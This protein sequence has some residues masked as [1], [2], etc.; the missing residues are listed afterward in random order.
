MPIK[1]KITLLLLVFEC[2]IIKY[3]H[4]QSY[5][6]PVYS[7]GIGYGNSNSILH[8]IIVGDNDTLNDPYS[9][10][11][12]SN[13]YGYDYGLVLNLT[14]GNTY[15]GSIT[16]GG[17]GFIN[18]SHDFV[19]IWIDYNDD[20]IFS[21]NETIALI[22]GMDTSG[23][24]DF[25]F[26]VPDT[27]FAST[28]SGNCRIRVRMVEDADSAAAISPC[29]SA[30]YGETEDYTIHLGYYPICQGQ[31]E[32]GA[33][34]RDSVF[35]VCSGEE[36]VLADTG[37]TQNKAGLTFQWQQKTTNSV[38]SNI[39]NGNHLEL[40]LTSGITDTTSF[41]FYILCDSS[42]LSDTSAVITAVLNPPDMCYC[43]PI[44]P[45]QTSGCYLG[46][47][48]NSFKLI[49]D[50]D[51]LY[52]AN[53]GCSVAAFGDF[54]ALSAPDLT[55]GN[56]YSG[57]VHASTS[58]I[59]TPSIPTVKIWIDYNND[60]S[61]DSTE[62]VAGVYNPVG[63]SLGNFSFT[64][65]SSATVGYHRM[66]LRFQNLDIFFGT[67]SLITPCGNQGLGETEDYTVYIKSASNCSGQ[68]EAGV[69]KSKPYFKVCSGEA[70]SLTDT[71]FSSNNGI[72]Y[73]WQQR[74][75]SG[76]GIWTN[77]SG[78]NSPMLHLANGITDS[79]DFRF[80]VTCS[81]NGLSDTT[82]SVTAT[83]NESKK[84]F[85]IPKYDIGCYEVSIQD[86]ILIGE[87]TTLTNLNSGCSP[88]SYG[89]YTFLAAPD[90]LPMHSYAT[91]I[92][93]DM[94]L[95]NYG[96]ARIWIDFND[97]GI[98]S[99]NETVATLDS[100]MYGYAEDSIRVSIPLYA[101][102]GIHRLR[103]RV[104]D[105]PN[106]QQIDP[107]N[108]HFNSIGEAEDYLVAI[109][110]LPICTGQPEAGNLDTS[111]FSICSGIPFVLKDTGASL[112]STM[113]YQWQKRVSGGSWTDIPGAN[114]F[115]LNDSNGVSVSTDFR[116]YVICTN[117]GLRDSSA[118][119]S[120]TLNDPT[121]C[122]C[123]PAYTYGCTGSNYINSFSLSGYNST[124][125]S[126]PNNGCG[127]SSGYSD[128]TTLTPPDFY[129]GLNYSGTMVINSLSPDLEDVRIWIDLN[130]D[131]IFDSTE[132]VTEIQGLDTGINNFSFS[133]PYFIDSGQHRMRVRMVYTLPPNQINPCGFNYYG[134]TE[135]Y[136]LN[137]LP[138]ASCSGQPDAGAIDS[139][140]VFHI[141]AGLPFALTDTGLTI[142]EGIHFQW[143]KRSDSSNN[144]WVD[145][146]GATS[147][148]LS[149]P[150]GVTDT[151]K[152]RFYV[153]CLNSGLS[154]TS[155]AVTAI[156]KPLLECYCTPSY[157]V[158]CDPLFPVDI[159]GFNLQ[160]E[161]GTS[162]SNDNSGCSTNEVG[163]FTSLAAPDLIPGNTYSGSYRLESFNF[164]T[165]N[166]KIWI[167]YNNNA[168]FDNSEVVFLKN[169]ADTG[170]NPFQFT[171]PIS[172][173]SGNHRLRIRYAIDTPADEIS[174]CENIYYGET[175]D[176][177]V[178]ILPLPICTGQPNAG[179]IDTFS[180]F[181][182]CPGRGFSLTDTGANQAADMDYHWQM[183]HPQ[184]TNTWADI[185]NAH[186]FI[187]A[188]PNGISMPTDFRFITTCDISGLSDTTEIV[189]AIINSDSQCYCIPAYQNGCGGGYNINTFKLFGDNNT[190]INN[191]NTGCSNNGY[192]NYTNLIPP[193][194]TNGSDYQGYI[195]SDALFPN[196]TYVK[197]WIDFNDNGVFDS[198][199]AV[200]TI[201]GLPYSGYSNFTLTI[202]FTAGGGVHT[203][204]VRLIESDTIPT[205]ITPCDTIY[206]G[207]TEDYKVNVNH[208]P[209]CFGLP[210]SG[211]IDSPAVF[212]V[213]RQADFALTAHGATSSVLGITY[214]WQSKNHNDLTWNNISNS[215]DTILNINNGITDTTDYRFIVFCNVS[216]QSDTSALVTANI[217]TANCYCVPT[218]NSNH[219]DFHYINSFNTTGALTDVHNPSGREPGNYKDYS[220]QDTIVVYRGMQISTSISV[221]GSFAHYY[222]WID[223]DHDLTFN[224][225]SEQVI[226]SNSV[227]FSSIYSSTITIPNTAP[228]GLSRLRI[229][230]TS[231]STPVGPCGNDNS[232]ET[233]DY[234]VWVKDVP[235][236]SSISLP[237]I[238]PAATIDQDTSCKF[239][240]VNLDL[241][242]NLAV[243][244]LT[245]QW[246]RSFDGISGW[247][248][249]ASAQNNPA[250][251][252]YGIDTS[253]WYRCQILCNGSAISTSNTVAVFVISPEFAG[254]PQGAERCGNG[255]LTLTANANQGSSIY[256]YNSSTDTAVLATGNT[257]I[258][259]L[260]TQTKFYWVAAAKNG[261][262]SYRQLVY[263]TIHAIPSINLGADD[264]LCSGDSITLVSGNTS[265]T[266]SVLWNNGATANS[267]IVSNAGNYAVTITNQ[268]GCSASD[269]IE[270]TALAKPTVNLGTDTAFCVGN[271]MTLFTGSANAGL[272][273][274]W[275]NG[276]NADSL[277]V[278]ASGNYYVTVTN[279][280]GCSASDSINIV[281]HPHPNVNLGADT[282]LCE[283]SF[284]TLIVSD[285]TSVTTES[286]SDG[287]T[288]DSLVASIAGNYYVTA[289]NQ[290]G[291]SAS[292]SI[293]ITALAKPT[294]NLGT[295]TAFC[296]GN[297]MT[298]FTGSAN[299]GLTTLWNNG[300]NADSLE[301]AVSGNY[302][303]TVTNGNG[304][305]ASDSIN[306]VVHPHPNVNLGA[307][308]SICEGSFLTLIVS[309]TSCGTAESWNDGSTNDSLVVFNAS[310]YFVTATN[311]YGC[312]ATDSIM[313]AID[314]LPRADSI[315]VNNTSSNCAFSLS[316]SNPRFINSY[317]WNFGDSSAHA[318]QPQ[319]NHSYNDSA[320][321][322]VT[323]IISNACGSDT[324]TRM[325]A[326]MPNSINPVK[327]EDSKLSLYPNPAYRL[328]TLNNAGSLKME[329]ISVYNSL[330]QKLFQDKI[331]NPY[332]YQF[333]VQ[334]FASGVYQAV[335]QFVNG[336]WTERK[337]VIER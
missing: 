39:P 155:A 96:F 300:T 298:L 145:I 82:A 125:L 227:I 324:L 12:Y 161:N 59:I 114:T 84:C 10:G 54:T 43:E 238:L 48:I 45:L 52:N 330:G 72:T 224:D 194:L 187:L 2:F 321:Y 273:T 164:N 31:P 312:S 197:M 175:E 24:N 181:G 112:A 28:L 68:P 74:F 105:A 165:A 180:T 318:Q 271:T 14:A 88:N 237:T 329:Y 302:Y 284:L 213:C 232:G 292:D 53:S 15:Q 166:I 251:G 154:D 85:C 44:T 22:N 223:W 67:L 143:Q 176:Y 121:T 228:F 129:P 195:A 297:T 226:N 40:K 111:S 13:G 301:V 263:A 133:I 192:A 147:L 89:D 179:A 268:Y 16:T 99:P 264:S 98:F 5:C 130:N 177:L 167:D 240:D 320:A 115:I 246:E 169:S 73:Q 336:S 291:C 247:T 3:C 231:A 225:S 36:L 289:T 170:A 201:N 150:N 69:L 41:R 266:S 314:S 184:G 64:V 34:N 30:A 110:A 63:L 313:I 95:S 242:T 319:V 287:S 135:D 204:R 80:Y 102:S 325:I 27:A 203:M 37:S 221:V 259:P 185:P 157:S 253:T 255:M 275:N 128:F 218:N 316:V 29:D 333:N 91:K 49:G 254:L 104:L 250:K 83:M 335:I 326:C 311:Q 11:F 172:A 307:D 124:S 113:T 258:T 18:P 331:T 163:D 267:L 142:A 281:V 233:E 252:V 323:L 332:F 327:I 127:N 220:L 132:T 156:I 6:S 137:V 149:F 35:G 283:G 208:L 57:T 295:D 189:S 126:N 174:A 76:T 38:W 299:A 26:T 286:W 249:L 71:G 33:I 290:Y 90:L 186:N 70:L 198:V 79:T 248:S 334:K 288:N 308:T 245:Y 162:I 117:T 77:I 193:D 207:E 123:T 265:A 285:T 260:L 211:I 188:L 56:T 65:P 17:S 278:A 93:T 9:N 182:V 199:E 328:V 168:Q 118:V 337:F 25:S 158:G 270:I 196:N 8:F 229:R 51:T 21:D 269:S 296:V 306:I 294:V 279:G 107:C 141:C 62:V 235:A 219:P 280:N 234:A 116:F 7:S 151:T 61:F 215:N 122:Y 159:S 19:R 315:I 60:G 282:S 1:Y 305:S 303:V 205:S 81:S 32:A 92:R 87:H 191:A 140:N 190:S 261:C 119:V 293:E 66:R 202:P 108:N 304:C 134:E 173:D 86:F 103:L 262:E 274:L 178:N 243:S 217:D 317:D 101:P 131:G 236:C 200:K 42:N 241:D 210:N 206:E 120:V 310:N 146:A 272:T 222:G 257:Y 148:T 322:E 160:G 239:G 94:F 244:G 139:P 50:H 144:S 276:T 277:E 152:F 78:A 216:G 47:Q 209:I 106:G 136:E 46:D 75:P 109:N 138:L 100:L 183:R 309:D 212:G 171:V 58:F 230:T 97:D 55:I 153:V 214:K 20:G 4:A 256:W 23:T